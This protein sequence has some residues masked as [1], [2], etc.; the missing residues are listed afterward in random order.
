MPQKIWSNPENPPRGIA[1][2]LGITRHQ[3]REAIYRIKEDFQLGPRDRLTIWDDGSVTDE[4]G[5]LIANIYDE[6]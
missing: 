5:E 4:D 6:I 1:T 2:R 3:L